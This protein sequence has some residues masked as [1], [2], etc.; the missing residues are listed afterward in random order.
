MCKCEGSVHI[1]LFCR[2][3]PLLFARSLPGEVLST[4]GWM[5]EVSLA[6]CIPGLLPV[7]PDGDEVVR[8]TPSCQ[9]R[10][11]FAISF[12]SWVEHTVEI[13]SSGIPDKNLY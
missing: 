13:E 7:V 10:V 12:V 9:Y 2:F 6:P 5:P 3:R 4:L 11:F 1:Y 8:G